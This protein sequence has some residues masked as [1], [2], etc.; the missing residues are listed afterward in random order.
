[1]HDRFG[2]AHQKVVLARIE[3]W[4]YEGRLNVHR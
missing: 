4:Q 1:M 2:D 3:Q